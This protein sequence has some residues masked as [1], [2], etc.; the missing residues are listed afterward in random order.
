MARPASGM[1]HRTSTLPV[2]AR[3]LPADPY[4]GAGLVNQPNRQSLGLRSSTPV[5]DTVPPGLPPGGLIEVIANEERA[6][7]MRRGSP[8]VPLNMRESM[9]GGPGTLLGQQ[10]MRMSQVP[11]F[12]F[13]PPQQQFPMSNDGQTQAQMTQ[14]MQ[15]QMQFM[16]QMMQNMQMGM[17]ANPNNNFLSPNN[18]MPNQPRPVSMVSN[19]SFAPNGG[20]PGTPRQYDQRTLSMLD[21]S[22][23]RR[24]NQHQ[25]NN[26]QSFIP[27]LSDLDQ[28][29]F[30]STDPG[31][32]AS[33]APS[34]RSNVGRSARYR[35]V[36]AAAQ[37]PNA[38][39][40]AQ[41]SST[42]TSSTLQPPS[43]DGLRRNSISAST[44]LA[45]GAAAHS[46]TARPASLLRPPSA[47]PVASSGLRNSVP[48]PDDDDEDGW[49]EML[50]AREKKKN[51]WKFKKGVSGLS[52]LFIGAHDKI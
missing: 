10:Q 42:F 46:P 36:S 25:N 27:P 16:Q 7:M 49:E 22:M 44:S 14:F 31:Y 50:E 15:M 26:R 29:L 51:G 37:S 30:G 17:N 12:D 20:T 43:A 11:A 45:P 3:N 9:V 13:P 19:R 47:M 32:A 40:A 4:Y 33:I 28:G 21:P 1:G 18:M 52:D 48:G 34:E 6:R 5:P 41:R 39:P 38:P 35:P 2:F 8:N 23:S 24:F